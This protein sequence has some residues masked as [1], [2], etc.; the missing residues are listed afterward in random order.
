[1]PTP[2]PEP[3]H[4]TAYGA[5]ML[6]GVAVTALMWARAH[7]RDAR[8]PWIYLA[9][10]IGALVGAKIVYL[11]AEGW[12]DWG[13]PDRWLR[14]ATGK[15][16]LGSLLFGYVAVEGAKKALGYTAPTGDGFAVLAPVGIGLGRVGCW[17]HGCCA[18]RVLPPA[19]Y[20]VTDA[21]GVSRWPSV[22]LELGFNVA[23]LLVVLVLRAAR[24]A[25]GQLFHGYLV[26]Y[27]VF[28]FLH[29]FERATPR[30]LG[31]LSGYQFAAVA[32]AVLGA[33][34]AWQ[35]ARSGS[36]RV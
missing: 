4:V 20:T 17:V 19:W 18:G 34:R 3:Q 32:V 25:P 23:A 31:S 8:L 16:V 22:P 14:L 11:L 9:A 15:S 30:I 12:N 24:R 36:P 13:R 33:W 35:R 2:G 1:M 21:S 10:L 5:W 27:G 26:A 6:A 29:E 7:R 28:R